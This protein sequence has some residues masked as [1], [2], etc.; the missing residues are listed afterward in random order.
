MLILLHVIIL[1]R[2]CWWIIFNN[3]PASG[4]KTFLLLYHKITKKSYS[5][6]SILN[7][8]LEFVA[9][10]GLFFIKITIKIMLP[11]MSGFSI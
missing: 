4:Q 1:C 8:V 10:F 5:W 3:H 2:I 11:N 7:K 6:K 9:E